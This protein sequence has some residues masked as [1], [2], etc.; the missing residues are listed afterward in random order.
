M[1]GTF[2][3]LSDRELVKT[4]IGLKATDEEVDQ[5]LRILAKEDHSP[6]AVEMLD[7]KNNSTTAKRYLKLC[8]SI[9]LAR[10][11]SEASQLR[12]T[13]MIKAPKDVCELMWPIYDGLQ[14]EAF[15]VLCLNTKQ[16]FIKMTMA[17]LGSLNS[18]IVH[19]REIYIEAIAASA[20]SIVITHNHPSGDP[21][22]SGADIQL[23]RRLAKAGD[24]LGI[25][26]LD[27]IVIGGEASY[28]SMRDQG[29]I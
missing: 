18:A 17:S 19:P 14:K 22:P 5:L 23:T 3:N 2:R 24:T 16:R 6:S 13:W 27:H 29:M 15:Y 21:E 4:I 1:N 26:L 7:N 10:R 20:A 25:E 28:V 9:E 12:K 11:L 8:S